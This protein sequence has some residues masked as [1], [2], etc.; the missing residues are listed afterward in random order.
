MIE[1]KPDTDLGEWRTIGQYS[2]RLEVG[3]GENDYR[4]VIRD[5]SSGIEDVGTSYIFRTDAGAAYWAAF[6]CLKSI[7]RLAGTETIL[8]LQG[9]L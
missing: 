1:Y 6:E 3:I 5:E 8:R 9:K 4:I 2:V 7:T